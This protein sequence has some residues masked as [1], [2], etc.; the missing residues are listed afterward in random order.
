M[1]IRLVTFDALHTLLTPRLPIYIQYSQTFAPYLG[2]LEPGLLRQSFKVA[3]TQVQ[4]DKPAYQGE[5]GA[6]GWWSEVIKRTA[7][8]AGANPQAVDSSLPQIV[9]SLMERFSSREGY[10]LFHDSLPVLRRLHQMNIR[11]A[12]ISNTDTRMRSVLKD[13][14]IAPYLDPILLSEEV[15]I[16]KPDV[17]VFRLAF[18]TQLD[19]IKL[20]GVHVGDELESDYHGA[21][22]AGMH[23]L[24]LRRAGPEGD[25]ERKE[26]GEDLQGVQVVNDLWGV[27]KWVEQQTTGSC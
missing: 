15:G 12:L 13:L 7:I 17:G 27:V 1:T 10:K 24:L 20:Q 9:P 8:G 5:S 18:G 11:T 6:E 25:G 22:A 26:E 2:V 19:P 16:E 14:E 4:K 21:R 3:L 23:A